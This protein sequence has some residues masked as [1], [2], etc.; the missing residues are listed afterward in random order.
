MRRV[1]TDTVGSAIAGGGNKQNVLISAS[2]DRIEQSLRRFELA[3][4]RKSGKSP[5][6]RM[7]GA[8]AGNCIFS[9]RGCDDGRADH[10]VDELAVLGR[11]SDGKATCR[12]ARDLVD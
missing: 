7:L 8:M 12:L 4:W 9:A 5:H 1:V 10:A 6:R 2:I 11:R 3:D